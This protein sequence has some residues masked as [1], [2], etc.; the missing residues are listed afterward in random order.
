M[1]LEKD[2]RILTI[3]TEAL[4]QDFEPRD[5]I[6]FMCSEEI[7][8][9]DQQEVIL[10]MTR[11]ALRVMEFIRQYRKSANTLDPLIAYFEKYGQKHLAHVLSKNYLPEERSLLTP[12]ALEDRLFRE[13][14]VPRLPFYRVLRVNLLEKLESLLVNLS[15]QG[16]K[17]SNP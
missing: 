13:G 6:P 11:R 1:L 10:S 12:T 2:N 15:S 5:A 3:A 7:F 16:F 14:N 9:D 4:M 8:T 17:I